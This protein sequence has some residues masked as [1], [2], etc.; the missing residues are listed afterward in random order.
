MN[1]GILKSK[2]LDDLVMKHW[3]LVHPSSING[4]VN[5]TRQVLLNVAELN[6]W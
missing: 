1:N 5:P 6:I 4:Q 2:Y 3:F